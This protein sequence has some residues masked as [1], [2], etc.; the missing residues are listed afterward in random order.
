MPETA[1]LGVFFSSKS[2]F[3][4]SFLEEVE[5]FASPKFFFELLFFWECHILPAQHHPVDP[6]IYTVVARGVADLYP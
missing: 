5:L 2:K 6:D 4:S 1:L 3:E